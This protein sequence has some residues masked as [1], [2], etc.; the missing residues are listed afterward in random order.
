MD[1]GMGEPNIYDMIDY[2]F[3]GFMAFRFSYE[4]V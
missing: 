4:L 3:M 2:K 1:V